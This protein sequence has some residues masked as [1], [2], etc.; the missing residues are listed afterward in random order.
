MNWPLVSWKGRGG[1]PHLCQEDGRNKGVNSRE[2]PG[3]VSVERRAGVEKLQPRLRSLDLSH[4][5]W[6]SHLKASPTLLSLKKK[7]N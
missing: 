7:K 5:N 1:E 3:G 6:Q 4:R 2:E